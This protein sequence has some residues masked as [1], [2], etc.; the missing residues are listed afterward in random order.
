MAQ[1]AAQLER[2]THRTV[3]LL[4]KSEKLKLERL[5]ANHKIS[6]AEVLRRLIHEGDSV[7]NDKHEEEAIRA[8]LNLISTAAREAN[9]S[10]TRTMAK[11]DKLHKEL[12]QRKI[13]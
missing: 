9:Q 3:V 8:A 2:P 7:F 6:S 5:A 12:A 11:V 4:R 1:S 13:A 10:M